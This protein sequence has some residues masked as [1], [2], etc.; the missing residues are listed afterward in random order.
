[1]AIS[2][3]TFGDLVKSQVA[4]IQTRLRSAGK[5]GA[6]VDM[7]VGSVLRALTETNAAMGIWLQ[8][9]V[10][11][12]LRRARAATSTGANLDSWMADFSVNRTAGSYA[13]GDVAFGRHN[14]TNAQTTAYV[15]VGTEVSVTDG[16]I[17][18]LVIAGSSTDI[19]SGNFQVASGD[20]PARWVITGLVKTVRVQ[21]RD[22]G[23]LS[24][25][26]I[27]AIT[28]LNTAIP[29]V[30]SIYNFTPAVGG[31]DFESDAALRERFRLYVASRARGT[32]EAIGYAVLL[33]SPSLNY[34][35]IEGKTISGQSAPG[36]F[37]VL[38][39]DD[40]GT[41]SSSQISAVVASIENYRPIGTLFQVSVPTV[42]Q[43][44]VYVTIAVNTAI[45][46]L[47]DVKESAL[48]SIVAYIAKMQVGQ[49]LY[50]SS[51]S[52]Q[53]HKEVPGVLFFVELFA[54]FTD[55]DWTSSVV[56]ISDGEVCRVVPTNGV[57]LVT[58]EGTL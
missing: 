19:A 31:V 52:A 2:T 32:K 9:M 54:R 23:H 28:R 33:A 21:A 38:I 12:I 42:K 29:A 26:A 50:L 7:S 58:Q 46:D 39:S 1:M 53:V 40:N 11:E 10:L 35:I 45:Y 51:L 14:A 6:V 30:D 57:R 48:A 5:V 55:G 41:A 16:S 18:F 17:F 20:I 15:P 37:H 43:V 25:V 27:G 56:E 4:S 22:M 49:N 47:L 34:R 44:Y 8:A 24:N 13:T 36:F 3:K